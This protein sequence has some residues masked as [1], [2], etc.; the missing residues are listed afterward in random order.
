MNYFRHLPTKSNGKTWA[1]AREIKELILNVV[2]ERTDAAY[3]KDLLQ[4]VMETVRN[5]EFI[6]SH[7]ELDRFIVDNCKTIYFAE[8]ESTAI[9]AT[10]CLMLLAANPEWQERVRSEVL[11]AC[12]GQVP[13][14]ESIGTIKLLTMVINESLRLYPPATIV[15]REVFKDMK[16]GDNV[17]TKG[18]NV[19]A[20]V[21]TLHTNPEIWGNDSYEFNPQRFAAGVAKAC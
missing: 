3:E 14:V 7:E 2:N 12:S 20:F 5:E 11:D 1:L 17:I 18:V 16:F 19:W 4:M 10:S 6:R 13:D 8:Y 21:L 15:S 9:C